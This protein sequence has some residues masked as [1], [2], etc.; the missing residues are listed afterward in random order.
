MTP[1][2]DQ[3]GRVIVAAVRECGAREY[4]EERPERL[5]ES[6][7]SGYSVMTDNLR[8]AKA[9]AAFA[10]RK[11]FPVF[12]SAAIGRALG[13]GKPEAFLGILLAYRA[14]GKLPWYD[15]EVEAR[16]V[17]AIDAPMSSDGRRDEITHPVAALAELPRCSDP[18]LATLDQ[19]PRA[20][21]V[22]RPSEEEEPAL[23]DASRAEG[24]G[25]SSRS[26]SSRV[27]ERSY[28]VRNYDRPASKRRLEEELRQAVLNTGGRLK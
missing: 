18:T 25:R 6:L 20:G 3:I 24:V 28:A 4:F 27:Q 23:Y 13:A 9:Y 5:F 26:S 7:K 1:T 21:V 14:K 17:A 11:A 8:H 16:I 2:S 22:S 19:Q 12:P 10:L 15:P